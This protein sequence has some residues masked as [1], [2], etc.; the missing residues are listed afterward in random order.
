MLPSD[1]FPLFSLRHLM[2]PSVL[3]SGSSSVVSDQSRPQDV[4]LIMVPKRPHPRVVRTAAATAAG[5]GGC[6][7]AGGEDGLPRPGVPAPHRVDTP[8]Q[9]SPFGTDSRCHPR[10]T[11]HRRAPRTRRLRPSTPDRASPASRRAGPASPRA[12]PWHLRRRT[13]RRQNPTARG[14]GRRPGVEVLSTKSLEEPQFGP[15]L[16]HPSS[17]AIVASTKG[18]LAHAG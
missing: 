13:S 6:R 17:Y 10:P 16:D 12:H 8:P 14:S 1:R 15:S 5:R 3:R 7:S 4:P 18:E 9:T 2:H 11:N